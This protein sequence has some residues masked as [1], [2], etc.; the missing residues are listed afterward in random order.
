MSP[1]D[2]FK[3]LPVCCRPANTSSGLQEDFVA[4]LEIYIEFAQAGRV[5]PED[6][7]RQLEG[8][9]GLLQVLDDPSNLANQS[10]HAVEQVERLL[11]KDVLASLVAQFHVLDL[12]ARTLVVNI[13]SVLLRL[14]LPDGLNDQVLR[15]LTHHK[16]LLDMLLEGCHVEQIALH[17]GLMLRSF[18]RHKET[19]QR[20][21]EEQR[22]FSL[23]ELARHPSFEV[24][25]DAF[26]SL[27]QAFL[28]HK[29]QAAL[30]LV[31]NSQDFFWRYHLLLEET[32][33]VGLRQ[34]LKL[35]SDILLD[36]KLTRVM[37]PYVCDERH[38]QIHMNL[39]RDS[40]RIV[41]LEA[42]HVFKLFVANP[43]KPLKVQKILVKNKK[44][45]MHLI[46]HL[47]PGS[48]GEDVF[49]QDKEKV[50]V[51]LEKLMVLSPSPINSTK[52]KSL[53]NTPTG[54]DAG[55]DICDSASNIST[56]ASSADHLMASHKLAVRMSI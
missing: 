37:I 5:I 40:S 25:S 21:F 3:F 52:S 51:K 48:V 14:G 42:F 38:L 27:R 9:L 43:Q 50:L 18:I 49:A 29:E 24:S 30:W 41:R 4:K 31:A 44:G 2:F 8:L 54:K 39:L 12:K 35:L 20:I 7:V 10:M 32:N 28:E 19:V 34:A 55:F 26:C 1:Q 56:V 6:F 33:Y 36:P 15:Y 22:I 45:L 17:C 11:E 53:Y 13:F 16:R 23:V 47:Q 46:E